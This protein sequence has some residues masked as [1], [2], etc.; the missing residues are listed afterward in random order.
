MVIA[1]RFSI[2]AMARRPTWSLYRFSLAVGT[3]GSG[4]AFK[5]APA[6]KDFPLLGRGLK[7]Q[8]IK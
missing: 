2:A 1:S 8:G 4:P 6:Q 7:S 5:S 3:K